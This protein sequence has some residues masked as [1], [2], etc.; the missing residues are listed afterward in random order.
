MKTKRLTILL[1]ALAAAALPSPTMGATWNA[2]EDFSLSQSATSTWQY[3]YGTA[4]S[5]FSRLTYT[6]TVTSSGG[7][8]SEFWDT[9]FEN[10]LWNIPL[11]DRQVSGSP[12]HPEPGFRLRTRSA[13]IPATTSDVIVQWTAPSAGTYAYT[14]LFRLQDAY[15]TGVIGEVYANSTQLYD[16]LLVYPAPIRPR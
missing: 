6:E 1:A 4:G 2:L 9:P 10:R 14:G 8:T 15:P 7:Q 13:S 11:I 3:G 16:G 12:S 5:T